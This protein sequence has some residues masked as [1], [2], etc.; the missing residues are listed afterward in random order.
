MLQK[1]RTLQ[2]RALRR[3]PAL[4]A[5]F[6]QCLALVASC[7]VLT[8]AELS[9]GISVSL[10]AASLV[11]GVLA[12]GLSCWRRLASWWL[13]IQFLFPVMLVL[14]HAIQLPPALFLA[15]FVACVLL[16]WSTFRTQ[17]PYYPSTRAVWQAVA[18]L[19]PPGSRLHFIDIGSGFGGLVLYLAALRKDGRFDGIELAP[20]PWLVSLLRA[21]WQQRSRFMRGDYMHLNFDEYDVVFA[22]LSPAAMRLLWEKAHTE[23]RPGTLLLSYE[24][25]IAGQAPDIELFP[26]QNG[27]ALYGWRM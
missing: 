24:F 1:K 16:Y 6:H 17:V 21:R 8:V 19:L 22:Y 27:P 7:L 26:I 4:Q 25:A 14:V 20:L 15:L 9:A 5:L 3:A 18:R 10:G 2:S 13:P 12:A 23:M 11:Q